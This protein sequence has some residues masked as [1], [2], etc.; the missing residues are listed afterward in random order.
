LLFLHTFRT[1]ATYQLLVTAFDAEDRESALSRSITVVE[2]FTP[3]YCDEMLPCEHG[4]TCEQ[5]ECFFEGDS[6]I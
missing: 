6:S 4:A 3:P 2:R 5:G 1:P